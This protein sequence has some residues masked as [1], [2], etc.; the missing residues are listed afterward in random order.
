MA[1]QAVNAEWR[2]VAATPAVLVV[3]D[4]QSLAEMVAETLEADGFEAAWCCSPA[5]ALE[6]A[7]AGRF[8]AAVVDLQMPGM[9]GLALIDRLRSRDPDLQ[10]LVLTGHATFDSALLGLRQGVFDYLCKADL[11]GGALARRVRQAV[12]RVRLE[13]ERR[14]LVVRL[15]ILAATSAAIAAE[16]HLDPLLAQL[17]SSARGLC[18]AA[19]ARVALLAG[20]PRGPWTVSGA[21]GDGA[22]RLAGSALRIGEGPVALALETRTVQVHP[23]FRAEV[24]DPN[25]WV[26]FDTAWPGL[27]VAPIEHRGVLG[28][29]MAA[30]ARRPPFGHGERD[31]LAALARQGAVAIDNARQHAQAARVQTRAVRL[32]DAV[33]ARLERE[34]RPIEPGLVA[35]W[36]LTLRTLGGQRPSAEEEA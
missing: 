36:L 28:L 24:N 5:R 10:C 32:A 31:G 11:R 27:I 16:P 21:A 30:G 26:Q 2:G 15:G 9:D 33:Q 29:L 34:E 25:P 1:T 20:P 23:D 4:D 7:A 19:S 18:R 13:R 35:E 22:H 14:E 12:E 3:D 8:E 6:V 17:V